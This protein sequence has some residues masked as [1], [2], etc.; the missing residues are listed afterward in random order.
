ML[1]NSAQVSGVKRRSRLTG[2]KDTPQGGVLLL[3]VFQELLV[4]R[5][6]D[7]SLDELDRVKDV[8]KVGGPLRRDRFHGWIG[9]STGDGSHSRRVRPNGASADRPRTR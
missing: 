6:G 1:G 2:D 3:A 4:R 9:G 7:I 8:E 5:P